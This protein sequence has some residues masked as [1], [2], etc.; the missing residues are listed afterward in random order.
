MKKKLLLLALIFTFALAL[1]LNASALVEKS[2]A[3][4]VADY[5]NVL[6]DET[7]RMIISTNAALEK[8]TGGQIVVVTVEYLDGL[9]SDEYAVRLMNQWGVGDKTKNNGMLL[10][11]AT[12]ENKAWLTQGAGITG[13]FT[14]SKI[15]DLFNKYFWKDFDKGNYDTAVNAMFK[16]M[17]SWYEGYYHVNILSGSTGSTNSNVVTSSG[18]SYTMTNYKNSISLSSLIWLFIKIALVLFILFRIFSPWGVGR[19]F[20]GPRPYV[21]F[22]PFMFM[23]MPFFRGRHWDHHN[24][25]WRGGG[26]GFGGFGGGFGGHSGGGGGGGGGFGGGFGGHSGGGGG[27]RA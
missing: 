11:L 16:Q 3:F 23:G 4:Y 12:Q 27:G 13:S 1:P 15:N 8:T 7:E 6:T 10:L 20:Y 17:V 14:D 21:P 5:A 19:R 22:M 2:S 25:R 9:K 26:G 24:D 18:G